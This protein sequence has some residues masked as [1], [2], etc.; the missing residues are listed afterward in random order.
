[1][2]AWV[3]SRPACRLA[4]VKKAIRPILG[5]LAKMIMHSGTTWGQ[6]Q[7]H[8]AAV[9]GQSRSYPILEAAAGDDLEA[10]LDELRTGLHGDIEAVRFE[11]TTSSLR[12]L[13]FRLLASAMSSLHVLLRMSHRSLK[14]QIFRALEG[15]KENTELIAAW[16]VC[17]RDE[18]SAKLLE[19]YPDEPA[20]S[21]PE[22]QCLLEGLCS[23]L[24]CNIAAVECVHAKNREHTLLRSRGWVPTLETISAKHLCS[25]SNHAVCQ[26]MDGH[27]EGGADKSRTRNS[28]QRRGGGGA[29]RAYVHDRCARAGKSMHQ[30]GLRM[31]AT[32]YHALTDAVAELC[33]GSFV[34]LSLGPRRIMA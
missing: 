17:M 19:R 13:R 11:D 10:C 27:D 12:S 18:L 16:P 15:I 26:E 33:S 23:F 34:L 31:L 7:Q 4:V 6:Q 21:G 9:S 14:Y 29:F 24:P 30:V 25:F 22:A 28:R 32:E 5:Y 3:R 20:L 8:A 2:A 1:M